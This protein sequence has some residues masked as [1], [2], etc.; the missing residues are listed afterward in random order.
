MKYEMPMMPLAHMMNN[1]MTNP[2]FIRK[3]DFPP[4]VNFIIIMIRCNPFLSSLK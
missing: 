1:P 3:P 4:D 2:G